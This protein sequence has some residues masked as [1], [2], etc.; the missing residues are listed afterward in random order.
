MRGAVR[1]GILVLRKP[2]GPKLIEDEIPNI[3]GYKINDP[4]L[5]RRGSAASA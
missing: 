5:A 4:L 2:P 1:G 3:R